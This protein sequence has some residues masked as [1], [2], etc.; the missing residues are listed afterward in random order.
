M[1]DTKHYLS[2]IETFSLD[3]VNSGWKVLVG[4]HAPT[5]MKDAASCITK[6][7]VMIT[8]GE[9]AEKKISKDVYLWKGDGH[10]WFHMKSMIYPRFRHG[11]CSHNSKV[12]A[13]S[14]CDEYSC[15]EYDLHTDRW[16]ELTR[17][18]FC[19]SNMG[20]SYLIYGRPRIIVVAGNS[21]EPKRTVLIYD[22]GRNNWTSYDKGI[23]TAVHKC[24]LVLVPQS[25]VQ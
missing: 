23:T 1:D 22:F 24:F 6:E 14:G 4:Q 19:R 12:W 5:S 10:P 21:T 11:M 9:N 2:S 13:V 18:P 7:G 17:I 8:G 3:N 15:E 20:V 25:V 16:T